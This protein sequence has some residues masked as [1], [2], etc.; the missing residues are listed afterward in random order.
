MIGF[1]GIP[2]RFSEETSPAWVP[3]RER[4]AEL[5]SDTLKSLSRSCNFLQKRQSPVFQNSV[6]FRAFY[7]LR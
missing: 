7:K 4:S 2:T 1:V 5:E 6:K 3:H